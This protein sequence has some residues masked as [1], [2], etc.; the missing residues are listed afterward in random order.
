[1]LLVCFN[2]CICVCQFVIVRIL[3]R[4]RDD[5]MHSNHHAYQKKSLRFESIGSQLY[6]CYMKCIILEGS[7]RIYY[8]VE[9]E[10]NVPEAVQDN[11]WD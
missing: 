7:N 2:V 10:P 8:N 6:L 11:G 1:M 5:F 9:E 3:R 4:G